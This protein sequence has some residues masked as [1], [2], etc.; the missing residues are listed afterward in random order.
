MKTTSP[1]NEEIG[2][3][4]SRVAVDWKLNTRRRKVDAKHAKAMHLS[5]AGVHVPLDIERDPSLTSGPSEASFFKMRIDGSPTNTYSLSTNSSSVRFAGSGYSVGAGSL[6]APEYDHNLPQYLHETIEEPIS[7]GAMHIGMQPDEANMSRRV[8]GITLHPNPAPL[9]ADCAPIVRGKR[10]FALKS[11]SQGWPIEQNRGFAVASGTTRPLKRDPKTHTYDSVT[12][13]SI[14]KRMHTDSEGNLITRNNETTKGYSIAFENDSRLRQV[15][16]PLKASTLSLSPSDKNFLPTF[17]TEG[18]W[19]DYDS[20]GQGGHFS[21]RP[22]RSYD[23]STLR[24]PPRTAPT[25]LYSR[26]IDDNDEINEELGPALLDRGVF[27]RLVNAERAFREFGSANVSVEPGSGPSSLSAAIYGGSGTFSVSPF[28]VYNS[29]SPSSS[30]S[31]TPPRK[32]QSLSPPPGGE[33]VDNDNIQAIPKRS[34]S[35][36]K[37]KRFDASLHPNLVPVVAVNQRSNI[38]PS[39][40]SHKQLGGSMRL[41]DMQPKIGA[42][43]MGEPL[44]L[45]SRTMATIGRSSG[46][47]ANSLLN[48]T[49]FELDDATLQSSADMPRDRHH[50]HIPDRG[51]AYLGV[52][53]KTVQSE[54]GDVKSSVQFVGN[55]GGSPGGRTLRASQHIRLPDDIANAKVPLNARAGIPSSKEHDVNPR[56]VL[57]EDVHKQSLIAG[58]GNAV[59]T[60][61]GSPYGKISSKTYVRTDWESLAP[62]AVGLGVDAREAAE[63]ARNLTATGQ[64]GSSPFTTADTLYPGKIAPKARFASV[65]NYLRHSTGLNT[66]NPSVILSVPPPVTKRVELESFSV[67][68]LLVQR[69]SPG[70]SDDQSSRA[71]MSPSGLRE[72]S[73]TADIN[74]DSERS[75]SPS[76][77]RSSSPN[78]LPLYHPRALTTLRAHLNEKLEEARKPDLSTY[79]SK[80]KYHPTV[81]HLEIPQGAEGINRNEGDSTG[82]DALWRSGLPSPVHAVSNNIN[83]VLRTTLTDIHPPNKDYRNSQ[84]GKLSAALSR[85]GLILETDSG[86]V[87]EEQVTGRNLKDAIRTRHGAPSPLTT[88]NRLTDIHE[89]GVYSK[90]ALG[91]QA[92][93]EK[94]S[95][96]VINTYTLPM[97]I[98]QDAIK[99]TESFV[100]LPFPMETDSPRVLHK[101]KSSEAGS[102]SSHAT[103]RDIPQ[104]NSKRYHSQRPS[105]TAGDFAQ[106]IGHDMRATTFAL[107]GGTGEESNGAYG[108]RQAP[109]RTY[110]S[111]AEKLRTQI[112]IETIDK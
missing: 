58:G 52:P 82:I 93:S 26:G 104:S 66:E 65:H 54:S 79:S 95:G 98:L 42:I 55:R 60:L 2:A 36:T 92:Q 46:P 18:T 73:E 102:L 38:P 81:P 90:T 21:R 88:G 100:Q 12:A 14:S 103:Y 7:R 32:N 64:A 3:S 76:P 35:P 62:V 6:A 86:F 13:S 106:S 78:P 109:L 72:F 57:P 37:L 39:T 24:P 48:A 45:D 89:P 94:D 87:S 30:L 9:E 53:T 91:R 77:G 70:S 19:I 107:F 83:N 96:T 50:L 29:S 49:Y 112:G 85:E 61:S 51:T 25:L 34:I 80:V 8:L 56:P 41:S 11:G 84:L 31:N 17:D 69:G 20:R 63:S 22:P 108:A 74:N 75:S 28:K 105:T 47:R 59:Y 97:S 23:A 110:G 101:N 68:P 5:G 10:L 67:S 1:S 111:L 71:S 4:A 27:P 15:D 33:S 40:A 44:N 43:E 16:S 99:Y